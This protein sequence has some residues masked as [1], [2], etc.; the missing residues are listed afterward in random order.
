[1]KCCSSMLIRLE[2]GLF[3]REYVKWLNDTENDLDE[4]TA[5][6][7][8]YMNFNGGNVKKLAKAN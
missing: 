3:V 4:D 1:M 5:N 6:A 8:Y 7:L 2:Q